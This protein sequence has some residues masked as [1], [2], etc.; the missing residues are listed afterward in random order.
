[1]SSPDGDGFEYEI[2]TAQKDSLGNIIVLSRVLN[3]SPAPD[4]GFLKDYLP[5][6]TAQ[7]SVRRLIMDALEFREYSFLHSG[8]A[9][10]Q[11]F[12]QS[13]ANV[14]RIDF[15]AKESIPDRLAEVY[16]SMVSSAAVVPQ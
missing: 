12:T 9:V 8:F 6:K 11:L 2:G 5:S 3:P 16:E 15:L 14:Y 10:K 7:H 4:F 1:M 13:P